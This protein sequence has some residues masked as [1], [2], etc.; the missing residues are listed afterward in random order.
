MN[1]KLDRQTLQKHLAQLPVTHPERRAAVVPLMQSIQAER[2][3]LD[4]RGVEEVAQVTGLS[5]TEVEEL[6]TFYSLIYRHPA[7]RHVLRVCDSLCCSLQGADRLLEAAEQYSSVS[8][9]KISPDGA[10]SVLPS[11]CLGLCDQ[12]PAA[13]LDGEAVGPLNEAALQVLLRRLQE[14]D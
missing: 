9:G 11:I 14:V 4:D 12:A 5:T 10:F 1:D 2:G 6:A 3:H 7:G 13:L 8:L